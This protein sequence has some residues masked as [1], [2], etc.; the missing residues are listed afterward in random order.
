MRDE[1]SPGTLYMLILR[2]L[3]RGGW[4]WWLRCSPVG[5][6]HEKR[7]VSTPWQ[8]FATNDFSSV[9]GGTIRLAAPTD[10]YFI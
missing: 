9:D 6:L 5:G 3:A 8:L 4:W 2:T 7:R 10:R 1:I